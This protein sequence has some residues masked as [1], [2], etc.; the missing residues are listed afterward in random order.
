MYASS[1]RGY[2]SLFSC[3][4]VGNGDCLILIGVIAN[5]LSVK[6]SNGRPRRMSYEGELMMWTWKY[7]V[8]SPMRKGTFLARPRDQSQVPL[9]DSIF[10]RIRGSYARPS[11]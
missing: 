10:K 11:E 7:K 6:T 2:S 4:R 5:K 9:A 8:M 3:V 1:E